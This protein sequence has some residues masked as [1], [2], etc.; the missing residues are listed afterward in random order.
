MVPTYNSDPRSKLYAR[1]DT[2]RKI[3]VL[4]VDDLDSTREFIGYIL[5]QGG[6]KVI[7]ARDGKSALQCAE[8]NNPDVIL[9]DVLL[10]GLDGYSVC[11]QMKNHPFLKNRK[12]IIFSALN[13]EADKH[14]AR[15]V[16]ADAFLEKPVESAK[17]L[18]VIKSVLT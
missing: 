12:V 10:P 16:G 9:L 7:N 8:E 18:T 15:E 1:P 2:P 4:V 14:K 6:Y 17:L 3:T 13:S 11:S 5:Q